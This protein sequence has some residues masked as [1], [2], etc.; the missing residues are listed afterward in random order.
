MV[1]F[2]IFQDININPNHTFESLRLIKPMWY[3]H[4]KGG[5]MSS[6]PVPHLVDPSIVLDKNYDSRI[7]AELEASFLLLMKGW[8]Y[9]KDMN[10][11]LILKDTNRK[12]IIKD[13]FRFIRKHFHPGWSIVYFLYCIITLKNPIQ[14]FSAF[15]RTIVVKR[16]PVFTDPIGKTIIPGTDGLQ[17][18]NQKVPVRIIIPTYNRYDVLGD[19]LKDLEMQDYSYF[20]VTVVDQSIPYNKKFYDN[21]NLD[22]HLIRQENPGLW[23]A[24]NRAIQESKESIIALLDD[25][26]RINPNWLR[27]HL[28]CLNYFDAEVSAGVSIST[29]GAKVPENYSFYRLSDQLDTGNVLLYRSVFRT[30]GLFDKQFEGMRMGDS[31]FGIRV[32]KSGILMISNPESK[33]IHLKVKQGGLR[34]LGSWDSLRP[35]NLFNPRPIPSVLYLAYLHFEKS[36]IFRYLLISIPFSLSPYHWKST[37]KGIILSL[38]LFFLL[39]PLVIVQIIRSWII[40]NSLIKQG[41]NIEPMINSK[42]K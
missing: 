3:F 39:F 1:F 33:R 7:S 19:V 13:E 6:W 4:L 11:Q 21:Y 30:C 17:L 16:R 26:S 42:L 37:K 22:I 27:K 34:Q 10:D 9:K 12:P 14:V 15:I 20:S 28:Q 35:T 29:S 36:T 40:A 32:Y 24:R 23:R 2:I 18:I 5:E 38:F 25:D 31:E 8:I 41:P